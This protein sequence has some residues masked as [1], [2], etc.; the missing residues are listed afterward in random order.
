[1]GDMTCSTVQLLGAREGLGGFQS[2]CRE[3]LCMSA[4]ENPPWVCAVQGGM[5][6]SVWGRGRGQVLAVPKGVGE[7]LGMP[8]EEENRPGADAVQGA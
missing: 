6:H 2:R 5:T 8:A 4:E 7:G 1:M 3:L